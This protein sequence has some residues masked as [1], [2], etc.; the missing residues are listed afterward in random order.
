MDPSKSHFE[1]VPILKSF[2]LVIRKEGENDVLDFSSV[3]AQGKPFKGQL[4]Q[5]HKGGKVVMGSPQPEHFDDVTLA[6]PDDHHWVYAYR[7]NGKTVLERYVTLS[8]DGKSQESTVKV[9]PRR[10][11]EKP[12]VET[13]YLVKQ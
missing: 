1:N 2:T 13:L 3:D 5:P 6:V 8:A 4:T 12:F 9:L 7:K 11:G 10:P